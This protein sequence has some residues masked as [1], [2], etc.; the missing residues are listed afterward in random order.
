MDSLVHIVGTLWIYLRRKHY[1]RLAM[2]AEAE[3]AVMAETASGKRLLRIER[4]H[5]EIAGDIL[6]LQAPFTWASLRRSNAPIDRTPRRLATGM[7]NEN[8]IHASNESLV[9]VV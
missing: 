4:K 6:R 2:R 8:T 7:N 1:L 3:L 9:E 5:A